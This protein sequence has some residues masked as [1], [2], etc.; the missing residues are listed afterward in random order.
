M[1]N[2]KGLLE[3]SGKVRCKLVNKEVETTIPKYAKEGDA[4]LDFVATSITAITEHFIEYGTNLAVEI[5]FGYVGLL[6]PRSSISKTDLVLANSIGIIDS[7]YRGEVRFRFKTTYEP[8]TERLV[9]GKARERKAYS[10]GDKIGQLIIIPYPQV[11]LQ[12][13]DEL[14]ESERGDGGFGSSGK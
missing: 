3:L 10:I 7:G 12:L 1:I 2:A 13:V 9:H 6:V 11:E 5:P 14:E 4:G 8:T